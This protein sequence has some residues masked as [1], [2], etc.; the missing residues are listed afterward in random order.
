M[1]LSRMLFD[2]A[3]DYR[4]S[5]YS[6]TV[7]NLALFSLP[8]ASLPELKALSHSNLLPNTQIHLRGLTTWLLKKMSQS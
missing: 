6:R 3:N 8:Q 1:R 2:P 4:P 7:P 5:H